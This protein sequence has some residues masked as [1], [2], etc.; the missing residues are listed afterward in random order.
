VL[1]LI[2][3]ARP[4]FSPGDVVTQF[5][6]DLSRYGLRRVIGDRYGGDWPAEGF[7][8][9][10]VAY[11]PS[12]KTKSELYAT[13]L[14][15]LNSA[16]VEVLDDRRLTAQLLGLERR[17]A[18]G[19]RDSIDHRP[20]QHDDVV[21]ASAGALLLAAGTRPRP[22]VYIP[23]GVSR[24]GERQSHVG[25]IAGQASMAN[26]GVMSGQAEWV[27]GLYSR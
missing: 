6:A 11:E 13:F 8:R 9:H 22:L 3:E 16:I 10:G 23:E 17:T 26:R 27:R 1:D 4:P 2:R 19:G 7:K 15:L 20:G 12:E 25:R 21:N 18:W 14:P 24:I 5:A